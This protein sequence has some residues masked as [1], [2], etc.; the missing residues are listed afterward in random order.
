MFHCLSPP[1]ISRT[2]GPNPKNSVSLLDLQEDSACFMKPVLVQFPLTDIEILTIAL[3]R[4]SLPEGHPS[5]YCVVN[6]KAHF[7]GAVSLEFQSCAVFRCKALQRF[8]LYPGVQAG[9]K[10][11][12][13]QNHF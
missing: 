7:V 5:E 12:S 9:N 6:L 11:N 3:G 4:L 13:K 2:C 10:A 1:P 8:S